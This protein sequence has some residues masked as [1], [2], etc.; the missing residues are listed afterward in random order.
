[1]KRFFRAVSVVA[2]LIATTAGAAWSQSVDDELGEAISTVDGKKLY[3]V[4]LNN[5]PTADG[6]DLT[7]ILA[8]QSAFRG[9]AN[10]R[11]IGYTERSAHQK[12][13]NGLSV[14]VDPKDLGKL[15]R[16]GG[17]KSVQPVIEMSLPNEPPGEEL[18]LNTALQMTGAN[19][20]QNSLGL[21][22]AGIKVGI[23]DTGQ[24]YDHVAF[25]GD[26]VSRSDSPLFPTSR[27]IVGQDFVGNTWAPGQVPVPDARPDDCNGHGTHV[28]GIVGAGGGFP[29]VAPAVSFG[30]YK[31]FGCGNTTAADVML[32]AMERAFDDGMDVINMSIGAALQWPTYPTAAA[33]KSLV[34]QGMVVVA[35][36]GN[37]AVY[38]TYAGGAPGV[39]EKVI[40]VASFDNT[41]TNQGAIRV[42][43][44]LFGYTPATGGTAGVPTTGTFDMVKTG[45]P[46]TANDGC[47]PPLPGDLNGKAVLIQ[48]GTCGFYNKAINAQNQG[49]AAVILYN[50]VAAGVTP[51]IAGTPPVTIPVVIVSN[52]SGIAINNMIA[53]GATTMEWTGEVV[54]TPIANAGFISGFSSFGPAPD[55]ATKPDIGAPGGSIR[56]TIPIEQGSYGVISGTSMSSPHVAGAVALL[57]EAHPNTPAN[58]VRDRLQN[59]ADP[60]GLS[61]ANPG[62]LN[63][64]NRQGAG[65]LDIPGMITANTVVEPGK[66]SLGE[67]SGNPVVAS[68]T[69]NNN[70]DHSI[71]YSLGHSPALATGQNVAQAN[72]LFA[73]PLF[74][75]PSTVSFSVNPVVVPAGGSASVDVTVTANAGLADRSVFTGYIDVTPD[76]GSPDY[77]VPYTG[78]KGDYQSIAALTPTPFGF[79]W[80]AKRSGTTITNQPGGASYIMSGQ[81]FPVFAFHLDHQVSTFRMEA[82]NSVTGQSKHIITNI[83]NLSRNAAASSNGSGIGFF[84]TLTWD[85]STVHGNHDPEMLPNGTYVAKI[86][87]V[88]AMGDEGTPG[89]TETWTSPVITIARPDISLEAFWL[90]QNSVQPGD[91]VTLS[92]SVKNTRIDPRP[93]VNVEFLD[94]DVVIGSSVIDLGVGETAIVEVPWTVGAEA[95]HRIKVRVPALPTEEYTANNEIAID[96]NI[97]EA[98]VGVGNQG[99]RVLAFAPSKPNPSRGNVA[100]GFSLPKQ[101]PVS[102]EVFDISGR[103]LK[104]WRWSNLGAGD[105][106]VVWDGRTEANRSAPAGTVLLRLN[107][108]GKTLT[109]KAVRLN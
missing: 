16:M 17:I 49:A 90:S 102:L 21:S 81:D 57:L 97:G 69:I 9:A 94:N 12:L 26:G 75:A 86:T 67:T 47:V 46:A 84:F 87:V 43:G 15:R 51:N 107:A 37:D 79:P 52:A 27:S 108:M 104:S 105:H 54:T 106:S 56:S 34:N 65:M 89:H 83:K 29:G 100:F 10:A 40:S 42:N 38:A 25:G 44:Q 85:G 13:W 19:V 14:A 33:A 20:A 77:S 11:G 74:N 71:S 61:P 4:E 31:V 109:Q 41:H 63:A 80:L 93:A 18:D 23:I 99:P 72:G 45:V 59:S 7:A 32:L 53:A 76:D 28:S 82:F 5:P 66:I 6:G 98:I 70:S 35:S 1:M 92:A 48:R 58:G 91:Q 78:L 62:F 24:D 2:F 30:V 3:F 73:V 103:R 36:A 88:K 101:G 39:G 55:L 50:N 8:E 95:T 22:G 64:V 68:L 96:V 60:R